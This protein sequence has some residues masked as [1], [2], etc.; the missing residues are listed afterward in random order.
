M[1]RLLSALRARGRLIASV[2]TVVAVGIVASLFDST[3]HGTSPSAIHG[4]VDLSSWDFERSGPAALSGEWLFVDKRMSDEFSAV[5]QASPVLASVPGAWPVGGGAFGLPRHHG[6]GTYV[7]RV[8][9]PASAAG[10]KLAIQTG[11]AYS[12]HRLYANGVLVA[13][14]GIPSASGERELARAYSVIAPLPA[15]TS[16]LELR[17]DVSNHLSLYGGVLTAP[18]IG[19]EETIVSH[20]QL[21]IALSLFLIGAMFFAASYHFVVFVLTRDA[22]EVLWFGLFAA[23]LGIRTALIE[24]IAPFA[25][26]YLGQDWVWRIDIAVSVLLLPAAYRFFALSFPKR[27]SSRLGG[28]IGGVCL[29][30]AIV[31]LIGGPVPGEV[32]LKV[33]EL[34]AVIT[35]IYLTQAICRAAW[36][37]EH[38]ATLALVGWLLSAGATVHDIAMSNGFIQGPNLIPFGF[39]AFFLCL[40]GTMVARFR[41]AY[42]R[43]ENASLAMR[44]LNDDLESAVQART[45]ELQ[46]KIEELNLSRAAL[47]TAKAEAVSANVA[48]SRFL[49]NMSHELRTP[50]NS[51]L[52]FSEIIRAQTLGPLS[53]PRY[54]EYAS[55]IHDSGAHLLSLIGDILDLS[56]IEAGKWEILDE[57]IDVADISRD[58]LRLAETRD[59]RAEGITTLSI[60]RDLPCVRADRRAVLQMLIN[61]LSNALKFTPDGGRIVLG[62]RR[63]ADGGV[64]IEVSDTGVGMAPEDIPKAL[65]VFSQVDDSAS[66]RHEGTGLGLPIVKSLIE[67][68][69]GT[70]GLSSQKGRG[71]VAALLFPAERTVESIVTAA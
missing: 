65:A 29:L 38:G 47:E 57:P 31:T 1:A 24:P 18:T 23:L 4:A 22:G 9:L 32:V 11:Y 13:T 26:P 69:G 54:A 68:H 45:Q 60:G 19:L 17:R 48:K 16:V 44:A 66:R 42:R 15:N 33:Y 14:S 40:S 21:L 58:A 61:L 20:R 10:Q 30:G 3:P 35:I 51:I 56:R 71:T 43:A 25:L 67:L 59:R 5:D 12:A 55:D 2:A 36:V 27:L 39:L 34:I 63:R 7:L 62:A 41:E 8:T 6:F 53:D 64:T 52:G 46:T 49:A 37:Q 70:F 28:L 50:L